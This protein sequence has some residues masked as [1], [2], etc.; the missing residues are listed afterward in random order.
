MAVRALRQISAYRRRFR[1]QVQGGRWTRVGLRRW[2]SC[3]DS[4]WWP[5]SSRRTSPGRWCSRPQSGER[6]CWKTRKNKVQLRLNIFYTHVSWLW[7]TKSG[8][9]IK[10][11]LLCL[12]KNTSRKLQERVSKYIGTTCSQKDFYTFCVTTSALRNSTMWLGLVSAY[13]AAECVYDHAHLNFWGSVID[14][15]Q[16]SFSINPFLIFLINVSMTIQLIIARLPILSL[17]GLLFLKLNSML[18]NRIMPTK[19]F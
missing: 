2:W 11:L 15:L 19:P 5:R 13:K 12:T 8:F 1:L 3:S 16:K 6:E 10:L 18:T 9:E 4:L 14:H 17:D 7:D